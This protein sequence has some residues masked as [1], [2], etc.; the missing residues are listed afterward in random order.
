[1]TRTMMGPH[2]SLFNT[3]FAFGSVVGRADGGCAVRG[4]LKNGTTSSDFVNASLVQI[5]A[6]AV[7][8]LAPF[9]ET[10]INGSDVLCTRISTPFQ[11]ASIPRRRAAPAPAPGSP[12]GGDRTRHS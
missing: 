6:A 7:H 2:P 12:A 5:R 1:M 8:L 10:H 9:S 3:T 11:V 4:R